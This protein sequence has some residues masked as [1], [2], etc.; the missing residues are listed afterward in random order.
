MHS[1]AGSH[2]ITAPVGWY[3]WLAVAVL[4]DAVLLNSVLWHLR[5]IMISALLLVSFPAWH[6]IRGLD[7]F[8][9]NLLALRTWPSLFATIVL[10]PACAVSISGTAYLFVAGERYDSA[11]LSSIPP[12]AAFAALLLVL[13]LLLGIAL[14]REAF[15]LTEEEPAGVGWWARVKTVGTHPAAARQLRLS[16]LVLSVGGLVSAGMFFV[17]MLAFRLAAALPPLLAVEGYANVNQH[18]LVLATGVIWIGLLMLGGWRSDPAA[19]R[20]SHQLS[21]LTYVLVVINVVAIVMPGLAYLLDAFHTP[22]EVLLLAV[23]AF[24]LRWVGARSHRVPTGPILPVAPTDWPAHAEIAR[25]RLDGERVAVVI[26]AHGGGIQAAA[27]AT[28]VIHGLDRDGGGLLDRTVLMSGVSGGAVGLAHLTAAMKHHHDHGPLQPPPAPRGRLRRLWAPFLVPPQEG[29]PKRPTAQAR[30]AAVEGSLDALSWGFAIR[31]LLYAWYHSDP[32]DRGTAL[33]ADW[34]LIAHEAGY[35]PARALPMSSLEADTRAGRLPLTVLNTTVADTGQ[36][37]TIAPVPLPPLALRA[38]RGIG[39]AAM[40]EG[41]PSD[42]WQGAAARD[43]DWFSAARMASAFPFF[44]PMPEAAAVHDG[45]HFADGGYFDN[46]GVFTA[47]RWL[48]GVL[49]ELSGEIDRLVILE[50]NGFPL[51]APRRLTPFTANWLGPLSLLF[52]VRGA[53]QQVRNI[54]AIRHLARY[55]DEVEVA[56]VNV[57]WSR[58]DAGLGPDESEPLSWQLSPRQKQHVRQAW[59]RWSTRHGADVRALL[60][61]EATLQP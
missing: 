34:R 26:C 33:A 38:P 39:P 50:I 6:R 60:R 44:S 45:Y 40:A 37:F 49:Q 10:I 32:R 56:H 12:Q 2:G 29:Y 7:Q 31:D 18:L 48:D 52:Q 51:P 36:P 35:L 28:E 59:R 14:G 9:S 1:Q 41:Q 20:S 24:L 54:T 58:E 21:A 61:G 19:Q 42:W 43:L 53:N 30:R 15:Q 25:R 16:A 4:L 57:R 8:F 27:W 55:H 5:W 22:A 23:Y 11:L 47:Q 46:A 17:T 3:V 13:P